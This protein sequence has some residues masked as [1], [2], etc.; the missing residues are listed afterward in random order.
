T[1]NKV[2]GKSIY[3]SIDRKNLDMA[4]FI[5]PGQIIL[6]NCSDST[7]SEIEISLTSTALVL[8]HCN[9]ISI[10]DCNFSNNNMGLVLSYSNNN[11]ILRNNFD[12]NYNSGIYLSESNNNLI[13][14]NIFANND[15][16]LTPN[17]YYGEGPPGPVGTFDGVGVRLRD[18]NN[19][20]TIFENIIISN[21]IGIY[22]L[23]SSYT[24][25]RDNNIEDNYEYGVYLEGSHSEISRSILIY[26]NYFESNL[27]ENAYDNVNNTSWDNSSIG[28]YW[29]DYPGVDAND[30]GI[31][32]T[33]YSINGSAGSFDN[34]PIWDDG[35]GA[36]TPAY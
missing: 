31:G 25:I 8:S 29:N 6:V 30:D 3:F 13:Y 15:A 12:N 11:S 9:N 35:P 36:P 19:N 1:T 2:N 20:T 34:F 22:L 7:I 32:D 23:N 18:N 24:T 27:I 4:E 33:P 10:L 16:D 21:N 5:N 26:G 14:W 17:T 28:N